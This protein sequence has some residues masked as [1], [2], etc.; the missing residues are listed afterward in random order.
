MKLRE[1]VQFAAMAAFLLMA[2]V[3]VRAS[4]IPVTYSLAGTGTVVGATSATLTLDAIA[5]GSVLSENGDLNTAWN[6][7]TYSDEAVLDLD[8]GILHGKFTLSFA[9]GQTL[10]G[11][12][13]EDNTAIIA[14]PTETGPFI[15]TLTFTGGTGEFAG[16]TGSFSGEGFVGSTDFTVS[17]A[18]TIDTSAVPEPSSIMLLLSGST[19]IIAT[20]RRPTATCVFPRQ[21]QAM[22]ERQRA[23]SSVRC[24][25]DNNDAVD[26]E[27]A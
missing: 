2:T 22:G 3:P 23:R 24:G 27:L 16:A 12:V 18:G 6:P 4:A 5:L 13:F 19:L 9:A 20:L 21:A 15:Q 10:S 8:T 7:V 11:N 25:R 17:G 14:S 26:A 1:F